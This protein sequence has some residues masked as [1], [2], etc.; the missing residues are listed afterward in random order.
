MYLGLGESA[1][2]MILNMCLLCDLLQQK[3][4]PHNNENIQYLFDYIDKNL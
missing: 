2:I 4:W 3:H 1:V